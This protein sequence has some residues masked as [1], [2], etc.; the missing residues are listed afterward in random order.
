LESNGQA[1]VALRVSDWGSHSDR[2]KFEEAD[3]RTIVRW[4]GRGYRKL[5]LRND[6]SSWWDNLWDQSHGDSRCTAWKASTNGNS[7]EGIS[8][9]AETLQSLSANPSA[10]I[11]GR[12]LSMHRHQRQ[13]R[14]FHPETSKISQDSCMKRSNRL[15][16][17]ARNGQ[18]QTPSMQEK[19]EVSHSGTT[20]VQMIF[21]WTSSFSSNDEKSMS[22]IIPNSF[23]T[24]F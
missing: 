20:V 17:H 7:G 3:E 9:F 22:H 2:A 24:D 10:R 21:Q 18:N 14:T 19:I 15:S 6:V 13:L 5:V 12:S 4:Y 1:I 16:V 11:P 8:S 23:D